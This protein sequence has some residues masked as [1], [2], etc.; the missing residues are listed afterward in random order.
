[1]LGPIGALKGCLERLRGECE[2]RRAAQAKGLRLP[3]PPSPTVACL[4]PP[5]CPGTVPFVPAKPAGPPP[6]HGWLHEI[7]G[8]GKVPHGHGSHLGSLPGPEGAE[9]SRR[10]R[11]FQSQV[12]GG[13]QGREGCSP[14]GLPPAP[15][16]DAAA[17]GSAATEPASLGIARLWQGAEA[18]LL[19]HAAGSSGDGES[20]GWGGRM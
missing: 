8:G 9:L 20:R 4:Q 11:P 17:R 1:M 19:G 13:A 10:A 5:G 16:Q 18:A 14:P 12:P 7:T 2:E 3:S 15:V 6:R